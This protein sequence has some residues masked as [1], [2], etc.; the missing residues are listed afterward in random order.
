MIGIATQLI[1]VKN[2]KVEPNGLLQLFFFISNAVLN[3]P[4][5]NG[6]GSLYYYLSVG[7]KDDPRY[8]RELKPK[9]T[10]LEE[11]VS[12]WKRRGCTNWGAQ[13]AGLFH[14]FT[15]TGQDLEMALRIPAL[16]EN[17]KAL[18]FMC[19]VYVIFMEN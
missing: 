16:I 13:R 17:N 1:K 4:E 9:E 7:I 3:Y 14:S 5:T 2:G 18:N 12:L 10:Y 15:P 8:M 19:I 6:I 11:H